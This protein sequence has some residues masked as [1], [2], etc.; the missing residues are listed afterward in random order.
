MRLQRCLMKSFRVCTPS[1]IVLAKQMEED[2]MGELVD[3]MGTQ[4]NAYGISVRTPEGKR[5]LRKT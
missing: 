4:R 3:S 5:R 1:E 2:A